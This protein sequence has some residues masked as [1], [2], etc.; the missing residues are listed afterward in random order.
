MA[1]VHGVGVGV[2]PCGGKPQEP[3]A[4]LPVGEGHAVEELRR[5]CAR[6]GRE[7]FAQERRRA[8][9]EPELVLFGG[10]LRGRRRRRLGHQ[11]ERREWREWRG[12]GRAVKS[13][14][15]GGG[16]VVPGLLHRGQF[17]AQHRQ[18]L[19][20]RGR[21]ARG[22]CCCGGGGSGSGSCG[23]GDAGAGGGGFLRPEGC[24]EERLAAGRARAA[25]EGQVRR[26]ARVHRVSP[27]A[28]HAAPK[29][30]VLVVVAAAA[31]AT[32]VATVAI[33]VVAAHGARGCCG[34]RGGRGGR[35]QGGGAERTAEEKD[36]RE[37]EVAAGHRDAHCL[38]TAFVERRVAP[39][40][41]ILRRAHLR[42]RRLRRR[43]LLRRR[44]RTPCAG[45]RARA[46]ADAKD[47]EGSAAP[48]RELALEH[49]GRLRRQQ[50]FVASARVVVLVV[51][52]I[53]ILIFILIFIHVIPLLL[54]L[55]PLLLLA[56]VQRFL[57]LVLRAQYL[58]PSDDEPARRKSPPP[59]TAAALA[60]FA[61]L[62]HR[63]R[64]AV[65]PPRGC[66]S[67]HGVHGLCARH[68]ARVRPLIDPGCR[69]RSVVP[70]A[71]R[72]GGH[73]KAAEGARPERSAAAGHSGSSMMT[74]DRASVDI[75]LLARFMHVRPGRVVPNAFLVR[76][77]RCPTQIARSKGVRK[78]TAVAVALAVI[79]L[80]A[81]AAVIL[82]ISEEER[83]S[84][85]GGVRVFGE[86]FGRI[87]IWGPA[88]V[89]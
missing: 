12:V 5:R 24:E 23:G 67:A 72:G 46:A 75:I 41:Q 69:G 65:V 33:Q 64:S 88:H 50:A 86:Y 58:S 63:P 26:A 48:V 13:G 20:P 82:I 81:L 76:R 78:Q 73:V 42:R 34:G 22:S 16:D 51:V 9:H 11:R 2:A 18:A 40:E 61:V 3:P 19:G 14:L 29:A 47:G 21:T 28:T 60:A 77:H 66:G 7:L 49:R 89:A 59:P 35:T 56:L 31:T 80:T 1:R 43:R 62:A 32:P 87:G 37:A 83:V 44:A 6:L 68:T 10:R 79:I 84:V 17:R 4:P 57:D 55:L 8:R 85:I 27:E 53:V 25:A 52:L 70:V 39:Q 30:A 71:P 38:A 45:P 15:G 54:L 74:R 36:A